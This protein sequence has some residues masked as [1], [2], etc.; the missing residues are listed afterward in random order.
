MNS[1]CGAEAWKAAAVRMATFIVEN[2]NISENTND[3]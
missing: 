3:G 1:A 2:T